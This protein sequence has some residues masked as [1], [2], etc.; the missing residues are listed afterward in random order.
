MPHPHKHFASN[1]PSLPPA[2]RADWIAVLPL[3]AHEQHGP[4]L[5]FETD[6]I[7]AAGVTERLI[8][9]LPSHLPVTF[10]PV[11]PVGYSIEHMDVA[12][13]RTLA[14]DEAVH[15]WLG[16]AQTLSAQGVRKLV[17]LNAHGGNAPLMTIVATEAR[18]RFGM[19]VVAT[20][21]TRF[22]QPEGL[23]KPEDK[24]IDIHGG[25]IETSVMLA[26]RPDLVAMDKAENFASRQS[27]FAT[28]FTH[29]RAY[30]PHAF[31]W[32]M[33]D[34]NPKGVAGNAALATADKGERLLAHAVHGLIA[35]LE[36]IHAF[37][38]EKAFELPHHSSYMG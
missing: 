19:L 25:D 7:I 6:T 9:A 24:A 10:L 12:G 33:S 21:W 5:P 4:H 38:V 17:L 26:L 31:G 28:R 34:L 14:F 16:M 36:D 3:G 15:R 23:I 37:D 8:A 32:K 11:E 20:S 1:D 2:A 35:L 13:T 27:E 29:L 18:V 22:G 30:G